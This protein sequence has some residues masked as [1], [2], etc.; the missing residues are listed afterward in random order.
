MKQ[1]EAKF[2]KALVEGF[3][4]TFGVKSPN[5]FWSYMKGTKW[6]V[7]DL[8]FA[9]LGGSIWVEAKVG[10]NSLEKTQEGTIPRM[11]AGGATVW[12]LT[13]NHASK[14]D[15][16]VTAHHFGRPGPDWFLQGWKSFSTLAAW[17]RLLLPC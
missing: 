4:A 10:D 5:T 6:G 11:A 9:A 2:K 13:S 3:E 7:P 17:E 1:P 14:G 15:R 8:F 12:L 16:V